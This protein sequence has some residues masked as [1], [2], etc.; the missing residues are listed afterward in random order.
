[1]IAGLFWMHCAALTL[2][3]CDAWSEMWHEKD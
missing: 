1:M 2:A 3:W